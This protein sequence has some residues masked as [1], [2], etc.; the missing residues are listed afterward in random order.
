[1]TTFA[2]R[3]RATWSR[4]P[5]PLAGYRPSSIPVSPLS[6]RTVVTGGLM[7]TPRGSSLLLRSTPRSM[8]RSPLPAL[9]E[10]S[11]EGS[12][13]G[14]ER[15][16]D[17]RQPRRGNSTVMHAAESALFPDQLMPTYLRSGYRMLPAP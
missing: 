2:A 8:P 10:T 13:Y 9:Q 14:W 12:R 17:Q 4:L 16:M 7:P 3:E 6:I 1:M 11:V 15:F 5:L